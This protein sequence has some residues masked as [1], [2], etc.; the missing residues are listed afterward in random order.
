MHEI[1]QKAVT[2]CLLWK[3]C[4]IP[5]TRAKISANFLLNEVFALLKENGM[6]ISEIDTLRPDILD[7]ISDIVA[8]RSFEVITAKH[9]KEI[10]LAI[11][12]EP[13]LEVSDYIIVSKILEEV[14]DAEILAILDDLITANPKMVDQIKSGKTNVMGFFVGQTLKAVGGKAN[15]LKVKELVSNAFL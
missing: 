13:Y 14:G 4:A 15:P 10:L 8:L 9:A 2:V 7:G 3:R 5:E 11:W 6:T 1:T 12:A